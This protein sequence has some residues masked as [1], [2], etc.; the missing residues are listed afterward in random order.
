M[1]L[2]CVALPYYLAQNYSPDE[3]KWRLAVCRPSGAFRNAEVEGGL[4]PK[5]AHITGSV[6]FKRRSPLQLTSMMGFL[7]HKND[8]AFM[9]RWISQEEISA[10][11]ECLTWGRQK[12]NNKILEFY[13]TTFEAYAHATDTLMGRLRSVLPE[14]CTQCKIRASAKESRE[15]QQGTLLDTL[16]DETCG[17]VMLDPSCNPGSR[18]I[19]LQTLCH[20][21]STQSL[22]YVCVHSQVLRR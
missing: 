15:P 5:Y 17:Y 3:A 2:G 12:G 10:I 7:L 11:H 8:G 20:C 9:Q 1:A 4:V 19:Y 16:G 18:D 6:D 22:N 13:G 21:A 14:G